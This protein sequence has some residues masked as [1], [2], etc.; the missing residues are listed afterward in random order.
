MTDE[1]KRRKKLPKAV[2]Y[3]VLACALRG[4]G[5]AIRDFKEKFFVVER[6]NGIRAVLEE[7]D[8]GSK[9]VKWVDLERVASAILCYIEQHLARDEEYRLDFEG[10]LKCAKYWRASTP[11]IK[12]PQAFA[13][14]SDDTFCFHRL[15][16]DCSAD[17]DKTPLF[18]E[19]LSRTTNAEALVLFLGSL[20]YEW[21]PN[22]QYV[23]L[24]GDGRN[25]KGSIVR[26]FQKVFGVAAAS[27]DATKTDSRFW[28]SGIANKR[29]VVF[30]DTNSTSF[31]MSGQFKALS[32][33]DAVRIE[34]KGEKPYDKRINAKYIFLS[35]SL[36]MLTSGTSDIRRVILC[37]V[38]D[39]TTTPSA[40]WASAG[41]LRSQGRHAPE[42]A[43]TL[44]AAARWQDQLTAAGADVDVFDLAGIPGADGVL[45]KDL[46]DLA[47]VPVASLDD[48]VAAMFEP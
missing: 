43:M 48:D 33:G 28:T 47:R 17:P 37:C 30:P 39:L 35:N 7:I 10:A 6:E 15:P 42:H 16:F 5:V 20:F 31:V 29:L 13:E 34:N 14:L 1:Q 24:Y 8:P 44:E 25:G 9:I 27:E 40:T 41:G 12:E 46:N 19:F 3:Q 2:I 23:W 18:S 26:L 11:A 4:E 36:P 21:S 32:G 38:A 45:C 22:Q